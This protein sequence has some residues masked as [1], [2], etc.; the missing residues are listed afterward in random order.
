MIEGS[1]NSKD[2]KNWLETKNEKIPQKEIKQSMDLISPLFL[3]IFN[4]TCKTRIT[5]IEEKNINIGN[6]TKNY[7][8]LLYFKLI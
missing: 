5:K 4:T 7:L 2:W 3:E 1:K 8:F 6:K